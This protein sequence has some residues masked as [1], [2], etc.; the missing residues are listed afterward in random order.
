MTTTQTFSFT[1][2]GTSNDYDANRQ[3]IIDQYS[4]GWTITSDVRT[5][6]EQTIIITDTNI[7][8]YYVDGT[9]GDD[10]ND[11]S[12]WA[13][14]WKTLAHV[15]AQVEGILASNP[16]N[17]RIDIY[18]RG[19][20]ANEDLILAGALAGSTTVNVIHH[21]DDWTIVATGT[22]NTVAATALAHGMRELTFNGWVPAAADEGRWL[23]FTL[24]TNRIVYQALRVS[25]GTVT[26]STASVPAWLVGGGTVSVSIREPSVSGIQNLRY[27]YQRGQSWNTAFAWP[28]NVV[29]GITC[30]RFSAVQTNGLRFSV[31]ATGTLPIR[32]SHCWE[33]RSCIESDNF[34]VSRVLAAE[35]GLLGS[36]GTSETCRCGS[37]TTDVTA[38]G[39]L[40]AEASNYVFFGGFFANIVHCVMNPLSIYI[41]YCCTIG[42]ICE[43]LG[44]SHLSNLIVK[45]SGTTAVRFYRGAVGSVSKLSFLDVSAAGIASGLIWV[46]TLGMLQLASATIDGNNTGTGTNLY[47]CKVEKGGR[48]QMDACPTSLKGDDGDWYIEDGEAEFSAALTIAARKGDG[49][50]IYVGPNAKVHFGG[51][52]TKSATNPSEGGTAA[53]VL[54]ARRGARITQAAGSAFTLPAG[55]GNNATD[56]GANGAIDIETDCH[57][58][59]GTMAGGNAAATGTAVRVKRGSQLA[60][61][62]AAPTWGAAALVLGG[63]AAQ[64]MPANATSDLAAGTPENCWVLPGSG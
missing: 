59:L 61:A 48:L 25:G 58:S 32:V 39:S 13:A 49:P 5:T 7:R 47:G 53:P 44:T 37:W 12:S 27:G 1:F 42:V 2:D 18:V 30:E 8:R 43:Y 51:A 10:A 20:F 55:S 34:Y 54:R 60:H 40:R 50:D 24:G 36:P 9:L 45:C 22:V 26:I 21:V 19:T 63:S 62:G 4:N 35:F 46:D 23:V 64:A 28:A 11:G 56:Y 3:S 31:K 33:V 15:Q 17:L 29:L 57:V 16:G 14:A 41:Q 52:V 6:T 38:N